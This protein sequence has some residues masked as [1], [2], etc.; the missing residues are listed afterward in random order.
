MGGL[1]EIFI[2]TV[3]TSCVGGL[4][5]LLLIAL[6]PLTSRLFGYTW[7][8][9]IYL[10]ALVIM[11][12]PISFGTSYSPYPEPIVAEETEVQSDV[13]ATPAT[14]GNADVGA[15]DIQPPATAPETENRAGTYAVNAIGVLKYIWLA[16]AAVFL[17]GAAVSYARF[18]H[19]MSKSS[20]AAECA[21]FDDIKTQI[22]IRRKI[23]LKRS[24][25]TDAP[26]MVGIIRPT[27]ILPETDFTET[28]LC[29]VF[30]HELTHCKR[31]DL[32][33]K[34]FA[35]I[36]NALHWFNPLVYLLVRR[37]NE[38]CEISCDTAVTRDMSESEKKAYMRT[39]VNL[40]TDKGGKSY[41]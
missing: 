28:E 6:R 39:I 29:H 11:L 8:Y 9:Y 26:L 41:V 17:I 24:A 27:L 30:M 21:L 32:C 34:L 19:L 4:F 3:I 12:V 35:L 23:V 36:V 22:G 2:R 25:L 38:D 5:T 37:I 18:K 10:A 13:V 7:Q 33:Y 31:L 15:T 1:S 20:V 16:G 14:E 40:M